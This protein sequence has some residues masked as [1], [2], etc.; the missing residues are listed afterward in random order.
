MLLQ[1]HPTR[2]HKGAALRTFSLRITPD[3]L[4]RDHHQLGFLEN[5]SSSIQHGSLPEDHLLIQ[6][7]D[8]TRELTSQAWFGIYPEKKI[9][10]EQA[11]RPSEGKGIRTRK[12][13]T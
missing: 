10:D 1:L 9:K 8:L 12:R 2:A 3:L 13:T 7:E 4:V 6:L 11:K 5:P